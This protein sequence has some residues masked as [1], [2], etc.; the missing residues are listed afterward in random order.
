MS[1]NGALDVFFLAFLLKIKNREEILHNNVVLCVCVC[2]CV[3]STLT[4]LVSIMTVVPINS[5]LIYA[6]L[7][8]STRALTDCLLQCTDTRPDNVLS[9]SS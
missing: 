3:I 8:A 4:L 2:V 1:Q 7:A 5:V 6:E 9:S